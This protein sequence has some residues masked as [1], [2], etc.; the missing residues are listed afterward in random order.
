MA[1]EISKT[2][3]SMSIDIDHIMQAFGPYNS[4]VGRNVMRSVEDYRS[5]KPGDRVLLTHWTE[6]DESK[7]RMVAMERLT[8]RAVA[9]GPLT[10]MLQHHAH[11]HHM[12]RQTSAPTPDVNQISQARQ[13]VER[14]Y[15]KVDGNREF[16][17]A[18]FN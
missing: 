15:G 12:V 13:A 2:S 7:R 8:V 9:S 18:Y 1:T 4:A 10:L 5:V 16:V 3:M 17:V 14:Q 11:R 6:A